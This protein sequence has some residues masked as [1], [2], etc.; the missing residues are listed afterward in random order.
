MEEP[1]LV[2]KYRADLAD[3]EKGNERAQ[4]QVNKT[5]QE[6]KKA[7]SVAEKYGD[8]MAQV[9]TVM[10]GAFVTAGIAV[11]TAVYG[12][13]KQVDNFTKSLRI[14]SGTS[15]NYQRNLEALTEI[16][17]R[18]KKSIFGLAEGYNMLTRETRGTA[19]EGQPTVDMFNSLTNVASKT[20]FSVSDTTDRFAAFIDKMKEGTVD[21]KGLTN[22]LDKRLYESFLKVAKGIGASDAELNE[23]LKSS[24]RAVA[25]VLPALAAEFERSLGDIP[26]KEAHDLGEAF[27]YAYSKL[28]LLLNGLFETSGAESVLTKL[29]EDAGGF[30]D[31]LGKVNKAYGAIGTTGYAVGTASA[32]YLNT[33]IG[34]V[35]KA[36]NLLPFIEGKLP[37]VTEPSEMMAPYLEYANNQNKKPSMPNFPIS[38]EIKGS[39]FYIGT[40]NSLGLQAELEKTRA[41]AAEKENKKRIAN[42]KRLAGERKRA[43]DEIARQ[44]VQESKERIR[45]GELQAEKNVR[46]HYENRPSSNI[47]N[48]LLT[49]KGTE[50]DWNF[51]T[52]KVTEHFS[53]DTSS[54]AT[55][56][57]KLAHVIEQINELPGIDWAA[58][59]QADKL[60]KEQIELSQSAE[61][62]NEAVGQQLAEAFNAAGRSIPRAVGQMVG[63]VAMGGDE[64]NSV[65]NVFFQIAADLFDRVGEA[66]LTASG[67]FKAS[68]IAIKTM[69]PAVA[70]AGAVASF[71]A[72]QVLRSQIDNAGKEASRGFFTGTARVGALAPVGVDN[73]PINVSANEMILNTRH[74]RN[75][76]GLI[77][78]S[79]A[80]TAAGGSMVASKKD[81]DVLI[82][83][84]AA[85]DLAVVLKRG[86][87]KL[88]RLK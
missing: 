4:Q 20:G 28:T 46:E 9:S 25:Q 44:E 49:N 63:S 58:K 42:E 26:Q 88:N 77:N 29:T 45:D 78:G 73:I 36:T 27:E 86:Q 40:S 11:A 76:Y 15:D 67:I 59:I 22:E 33:L 65:G 83:K 39:Q 79:N 75:L 37:R 3:F 23:L 54:M 72:A 8:V 6:T 5:A 1:E 81:S 57:E 13:N 52:D 21:S 68:Q 84:W 51:A 19:N 69:N 17:D 82:A 2:F 31:V 14:S 66:L 7:S 61:A 24:D 85:D 16:A 12:A 71:A 60:K 38:G 43:L 74:Q 30:L 64:M 18:N 32:K 55:A 41:E 34:G 10:G 56:M 35:E 48:R 53:S 62:I 50:V 80:P 70:I 47:S 87:R